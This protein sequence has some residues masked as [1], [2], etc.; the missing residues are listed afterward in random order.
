[1]T[2]GLPSMQQLEG[3]RPKTI[4]KR[5]VTPSGHAIKLIQS[6][7]CSTSGRC[8]CGFHLCVWFAFFV[9]FYLLS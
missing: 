3:Q 2:T 8:G 1:M 7:R 5:S 9:L 6:N 4:K